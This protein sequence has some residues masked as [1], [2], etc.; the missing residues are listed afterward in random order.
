VEN[1][2]AAAVEAC[3]AIRRMVLGL[4]L[5]VSTTMML[6]QSVELPDWWG[7][8]FVIV[9]GGNVAAETIGRRLLAS[10]SNR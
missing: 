4:S 2:S 1:V 9:V 7:T 10:T 8:A 3:K 6:L 5:V